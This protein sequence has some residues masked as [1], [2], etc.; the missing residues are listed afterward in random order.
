MKVGEYATP[1][2][3]NVVALQAKLGAA[4]STVAMI[5]MGRRCG[6]WMTCNTSSI[7]KKPCQ[8]D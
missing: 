6:A 1:R 3:A 5:A 8:D 2:I 4:M 7:S